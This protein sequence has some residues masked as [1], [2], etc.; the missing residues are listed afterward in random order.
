MLK[1]VTRAHEYVIGVRR[2]KTRGV[3]GYV[4][5]LRQE[6]MGSITGAVKFVTRVHGYM[7]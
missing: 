3:G 5:P 7:T 4:G 6:Y 2:S 1:F